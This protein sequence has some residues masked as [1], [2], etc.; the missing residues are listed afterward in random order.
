MINPGRTEAGLASVLLAIFVGVFAWQTPS[1]W[2]HPLTAAEIDDFAAAL[3]RNLVQPPGEKA[4]FIARIRQWAATD[5]GRPVLLLNLMRFH[6][7]L[8][9]LPPDVDF[10]GTPAE[11]NEYYERIVAPLALQRG[12]YPLAAGDVQAASLTSSLEDGA[13]W[14][15]VVVMRAPSRRAFLEFMADPVYGPAVP[16]KLAA[17]EVALIPVDAGLVIP[18]VR[19]IAGGFLLAVFLAFGW[20]R[21]ARASRRA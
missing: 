17:T 18:D 1:L 2:Q 5:D 15:R 6:D 11:A 21:E 13:D 8:H 14:D 4:A 16:Y 10:D 20:W 19:W 9:A 7:R 12:E 3:D